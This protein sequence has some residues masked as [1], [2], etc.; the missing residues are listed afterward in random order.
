M[1]PDIGSLMEAKM[2][3]S[4]SR[5]Q[6]SSPPVNETAAESYALRGCVLLEW[7][8][9]FLGLNPKGIKRVSPEILESL[10]STCTACSHKQQCFDD[11]MDR[12]S[13]SVWGRYCLN[14]ETFALLSA[15][16]E[17]DISIK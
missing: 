15:S 17:P 1:R 7:R 6:K 13:R 14:A 2:D 11:M 9:T 5:K 16:D 12:V 10:R 3:S 8:L 4:G